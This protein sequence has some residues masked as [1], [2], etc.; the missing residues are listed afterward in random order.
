MQKILFICTGNICRSPVAEV[1][2]KTKLEKLGIL[3]QFQ[4]DSAAIQGH[5]IGEPPDHR[6]FIEGEK[7]GLNFAHIHSRQVHLNDYYQFELMLGMTKHHV[8]YLESHKPAD[9]IT[10]IA[11]FA[12]YA[13]Q[14][15][16]EDIEDPYYG[17]IENFIKMF[18]QIDKI[19]DKLIQQITQNGTVEN[20]NFL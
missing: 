13:D 18:D 20:L 19:S 15:L 8:D 12:N 2:C 9:S 11:L 17:N 6:V 4:I 16:H 3:T 1:I 5:H 10:K 7:R 14:N